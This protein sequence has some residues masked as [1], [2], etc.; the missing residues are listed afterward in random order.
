MPETQFTIGAAVRCVDGECGTLIRVVIDPVARAVTHVVVEPEHRGGLGKLVPLELVES[1]G[2]EVVLRCT[3][4][5]LSKLRY[6]EETDYLPGASGYLGY[7]SGTVLPL[8]YYG[9]G[10][11][12]SSLPVKY[13]RV[14]LGEVTIRRG[15]PVHATDGDI[16]KVQ[17]LVMD[18]VD[19][20]VTHILLQE[21]HIWDREEVA[22]PIS[23]VIAME[24]G[25][26]LSLTKEQVKDLPSVDVADHVA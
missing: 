13:D 19:R 21:G 26:R 11:G 25:I 24:S 15:D 16:G 12:N 18:P 1:V 22:I 6:A 5:D 7:D 8:P 10:P 9:L 14:P 23:A 20:H 17:G 3:L 4:E 2:D